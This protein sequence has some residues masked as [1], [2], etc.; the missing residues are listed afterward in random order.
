[1]DYNLMDKIHIRDLLVRTVIGIYPEERNIKQDILLNITIFADQKPAA[2]SDDFNLTV[3]YHA[4]QETVIKMVESSSFGLIETLASAIAELLLKVDGVSACRVVVDKPGV[5]RFS[6]SVA[7]EIFR[8][9][10]D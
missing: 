4:V 1:M 3:D 5:L 7:V 2:A 8:S 9:R 10:T 6:K